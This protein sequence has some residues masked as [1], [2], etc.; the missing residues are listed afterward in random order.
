M[1]QRAG[2]GWP[3]EPNESVDDDVPSAGLGWPTTG[4][5]A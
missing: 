1:E 4:E 3:Q 5:D 2:L